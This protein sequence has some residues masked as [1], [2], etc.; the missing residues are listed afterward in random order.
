MADYSFYIDIKV[1]PFV[2]QFLINE[3]GD[4]V[5]LDNEHRFKAVLT[6][7]LQKPTE[8]RKP[9][10]HNPDDCVVR[11][12]ISED[13]FHRHGFMLSRK[14]ER[15]FSNYVENHLKL[16]M[17]S[18]IFIMSHWHSIAQSIRMFQ[19]DWDLPE[20]VWSFDTIKKDISRH[21]DIRRNDN[22]SILMKKIDV[23]IKEEKARIDEETMYF[24][25]TQLQKLDL[26]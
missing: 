7:L 6:W 3:G 18:Q 8:Y 21:T 17:R 11:L 14:R 10:K 16:I 26:P 13:T 23:L 15:Y 1:K 12:I 2:K 19:D 5:V 4:P 22:L 25:K 24:L 20:E 9:I